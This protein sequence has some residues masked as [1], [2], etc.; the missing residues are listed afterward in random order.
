MNTN[1][2]RLAA[3]IGLLAI[4]FTCGCASTGS[5]KQSSLKPLKAFHEAKKTDVVVNFPGWSCI[6]VNKPIQLDGAFQR[7]Y[8]KES[9]QEFLA[10]IPAEQHNLIAIVCSVNSKDPGDMAR[11][12]GDIQEWR[13]I[14]KSMAFKRVVFLEANASRDVNW[15]PVLED[16]QLAE[17]VSVR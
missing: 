7:V 4:A 17:V 6:M 14:L 1:A 3:F 9:V 5:S 16:A 8:S 10:S 15:K 11:V 12:A 13:R 2:S